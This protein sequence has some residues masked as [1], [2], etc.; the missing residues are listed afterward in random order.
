MPLLYAWTHGVLNTHVQRTGPFYAVTLRVD[1]R[2]VQYTCTENG[3]V[4]CRYFTRGHTEC[5]IHMYRERDRFMPLL[6]AWTHGVLNTH[7]QRTGPFYAV[8][9]RVDTRSVKYTCTENGTVLCRYF[10]RGHTEC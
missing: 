10:T 7:V 8:T 5:S 6:Y 1:T 9:L 4:L 3:T 2:S